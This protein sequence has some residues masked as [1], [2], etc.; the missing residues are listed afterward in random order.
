MRP[1][2][3]P[4]SVSFHSQSQIHITYDPGTPKC[5]LEGQSHVN[6]VSFNVMGGFHEDLAQGGVGMNVPGNLCRG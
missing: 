2:L 6:C 3:R 5:F 1:K 4:H